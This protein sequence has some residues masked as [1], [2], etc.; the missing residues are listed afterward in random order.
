M[1]SYKDVMQTVND[2]ASK[3]AEIGN[4]KKLKELQIAYKE[5]Q[6][7]EE[8]ARLGYIICIKEFCEQYMNATSEKIK[9]EMGQN[10]FEK[11]FGYVK[12]ALSRL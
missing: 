4:D 1:V 3:L 10:C 5:I 8:R 9:F 12:D 7:E 2:C 11:N 6:N